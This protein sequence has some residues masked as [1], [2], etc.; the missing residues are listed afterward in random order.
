MGRI[1]STAVK[2]AGRTLVLLPEFTDDFEKNKEALETYTLPD[3]CT[4]N[5]IAG[6]IARLKKAEAKKVAVTQ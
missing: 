2:K 5:K 6:Y 3:K 4:R 1:K